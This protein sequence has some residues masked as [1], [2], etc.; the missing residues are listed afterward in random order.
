MMDAEESQTRLSHDERRE[1]IRSD[2]VAMNGDESF[3][4]DF[5]DVLTR[6]RYDTVLAW[7]GEAG[8]EKVRAKCEAIAALQIED[9]DDFE[10]PD[11]TPDDDS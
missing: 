1:K 10:M 11:L 3:K 6:K 9:D 4:V 5:R 2:F 7:L 8:N